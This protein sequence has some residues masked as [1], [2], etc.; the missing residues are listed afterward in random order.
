MGPIRERAVR[1]GLSKCKNFSR[2]TPVKRSDWKV[3]IPAAA[4][5]I[6]DLAVIVQ[7]MYVGEVWLHL[8]NLINNQCKKG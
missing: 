5:R 7:Q 2:K 3:D 8:F 6:R 4:G 1:R